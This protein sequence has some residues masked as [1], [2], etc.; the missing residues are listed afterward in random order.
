MLYDVI[1]CLLSKLGDLSFSLHF[2]CASYELDVYMCFVL[3]HAIFTEV[4]VLC[5]FI[6]VVTNTSMQSSLHD[7]A[8]FC[9]LVISAK[10]ESVI[11]CCYV[12]LLPP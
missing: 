4:P 9:D 1:C 11:F 8:D 3:H 7:V 6:Y 10:S 12:N 5:F 2:V